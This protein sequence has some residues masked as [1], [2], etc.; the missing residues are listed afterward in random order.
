MDVQK[1]SFKFHELT[2][3]EK[4]YSP[5]YLEESLANFRFML[6]LMSE[7]KFGTLALL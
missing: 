2:S 5:S 7:L 6:F 1:L 3:Y 4:L